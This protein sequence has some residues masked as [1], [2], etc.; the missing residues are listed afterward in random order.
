VLL[1][2]L[3]HHDQFDSLR[4]P[5]VFPEGDS[6]SV[7]GEDKKVAFVNPVS[8]EGRQASLN[9]RSAE[10]LAAMGLADSQVVDVAAPAIVSTEDHSHQMLSLT[11]HK[12]E[13]GIALQKARYA[14]PRI[15]VT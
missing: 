10:T 8:P 4:P 7:V 5:D 11:S 9:Q 1:S 13:A 6:V 14:F 12:A 15:R 3:G 2:V